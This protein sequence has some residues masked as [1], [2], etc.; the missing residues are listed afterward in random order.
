MHLRW[1]WQHPPLLWLSSICI[2]NV[3][4]CGLPRQIET[5]IIVF[6]RDDKTPGNSYL[7]ETH[8][9]TY[10]LQ[11]ETVTDVKN[12]SG[13]GWYKTRPTRVCVWFGR[14]LNLYHRDVP[15][16]SLTVTSWVGRSSCS[17]SEE[18]L[19]PSN[20]VSWPEYRRNYSLCGFGCG[21]SS[22]G[23]GFLLGCCSP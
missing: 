2:G 5:N 16:L 3:S 12:N 11:W 9:T 21:R 19:L 15:W 7:S 13:E 4:I 10:Q 14:R 22:C 18:T 17:R 20:W 23:G 8:S 6:T 1:K